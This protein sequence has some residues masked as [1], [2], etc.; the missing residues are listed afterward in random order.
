MIAFR[1]KVKLTLT[2]EDHV[3]P[4]QLVMMEFKIKVKSTSIAEVH[5]LIAVRIY[6]A[7]VELNKFYICP[8]KDIMKWKTWCNFLVSNVASK[9]VSWR[10][11]SR[12]KANGPRESH[13]DKQCHE[14]IPS[15]ASGYCEC[16]NGKKKMMKGCD[17]VAQYKNCND[18]CIG[19]DYARISNLTF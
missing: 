5:A 3:M 7:F 12:C 6:I 11:T 9:C 14:D 1:I 4:V 13:R 17:D 18:A 19:N 8:C 2:V 16:S 15:G 10:H